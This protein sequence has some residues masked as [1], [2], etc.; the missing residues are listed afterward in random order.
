MGC[1]CLSIVTSVAGAGLLGG[2]GGLAGGLGG[3]GGIAGGLGGLTGGLGS[4]GGLAGGL[5]GLGG[6]AGSLSSL[7][8]I[9]SIGSIAGSLGGLGGIPGIGGIGDLAGS[10]GGLG[11]NLIGDLAGS[12]SGIIGQIQ[13]SI[14][15]VVGDAINVCGDAVKGAL[16]DVA[17]SLTGAIG[18]D[19]LNTL[20]SQGI[21]LPTNNLFSSITESGAQFFQNGYAGLTECISISKGFCDSSAS[22]L[23]SFSAAGSQISSF[24]NLSST[25]GQMTGGAVNNLLNPVS[26][27]TQSLGQVASGAGSNPLSYIGTLQT[28]INQSQ[29]VFKSLTGDMNKWGTMFN[30]ASPNDFFS[31]VKLAENLV[32]K[33]VPSFN[34][35]LEANNINPFQIASVSEKKIKQILDSAPPAVVRDVVSS[36]EFQV[37][38]SKLSDV[39]KPEVALSDVTRNSFKDFDTVAKQINSIGPTTAQSFGELGAKLANIEFPQASVL[40]DLERDASKLRDILNPNSAARAQLSGTGSGVFGNPTMDDMMGSYTGTPYNI[41]LAGILQGQRR[42]AESPTGQAFAAAVA[43]AKANASIQFEGGGTTDEADAQAIRTAY[44]A[45]LNDADNK[46]IIQTMD[47]F[48]SDMQASLVREKQNLKAARLNPADVEGSIH[49]IFAF[50]QSLETAHQDDFKIGYRE[51]VESAA[52]DDVYGAAVRA[53]IVEGKNK[54]IVRELGLDISPASI[55]DFTEEEAARL[56]F[57]VEGVGVDAVKSGL[58]SRCCP[59]FNERGPSKPTDGLLET[60]CDGANLYGIYADSDGLNYARLI[61]ANTL[62]C[63]VAGIQFSV[64]WDTIV[65]SGGQVIITIS[66]DSP[67][68]DGTELTFTSF[69]NP[70]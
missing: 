36:T 44:Q 55:V 4:L 18:G 5:G 47:K 37:P 26:A 54:A 59:P 51:W 24:I 40:I 62:D 69:L 39:L 66:S 56:G 64:T 9:P 53:A 28:S 29:N 61:E 67:I 15:G 68:P 60:Y 21:S 50:L 13:G 38:I 31:P 8:S 7:G 22:M 17:G 16:G 43:Q 57:N 12:T 33:N 34:K 19:V 70:F 1:S 3:L 2:V 52:S 11:T 10:L 49:S 14:S 41:R 42:I 25:F 65:T 27:L 58:A 23:G 6:I 20:S 30:I 45:M 48:Y 63:L 46:E 32:Q 35:L